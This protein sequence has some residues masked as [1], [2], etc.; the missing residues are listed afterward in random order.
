MYRAAALMLLLLMPA[1]ALGGDAPAGS[2]FLTPHYS[3]RLAGIDQETIHMLESQGFFIEWAHG[4]KA[5]LYVDASQEELLTH[6][7]YLPVRVETSEPNVPY[8]TITALYASIDAVLAAHPDIC[9]SEIIGTSI[10]GRPLRA[11]VVTANPG[12]EEVE[13][14][15]RII[16]SIH[17]DEKTS[18]MVTLG[19]LQN[20]TDSYDDSPACQYIVDNTELW[21]VPVLNPDGYVANSRY[22]ANGIDLNRNLS[23]M[24]PGSGGGSTAFSEPETAAL[25]D[26]TMQDWPAVSNFVNPF[27]VALSLHGGAACFNAPWNYTSNPHPADYD[28]MVDQGNAYANSPGIV[29]YFGSGNF[30][31]WVPGADWY[32]TNGDVNDWS[33]GECGT[34]DHTIEVHVD[35]QASDWPG[36]ANAHYGAIMGFFTEGTYG[37]WGTVTDATGGPLDA[38]IQIGFSDG[39]DSEPLRF[40][41]TDVTLG[42]YCKALLPGTYDVMATVSGYTSQTVTS[43][44]VGASQRVEVSFVM[45]QVGIAGGDAGMAGQSLSAS[46]NPAS[47]YCELTFSGS[48]LG[49]SLSIYD[50]MG[51]QVLRTGIAAGVSSFTWDCRDAS[52]SFVPAGVYVARYETGG[53]ELTERL[54]LGR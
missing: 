7:G 21:V 53:I 6:L 8:P 52:G 11:V 20:L 41:R 12:V 17:G 25:R 54:V 18:A 14:E 32:P 47:G 45:N 38:L 48:G 36:V 46:P 29:S 1:F 5:S 44:V 50:I 27:T 30:D 3:V 43:V 28:L 2:L 15:L 23:Y 49:G 51:R 26:I 22:N 19:F 16:G 24:G 13:P 4:D 9:R 40:C 34:V 39:T 37:I 42:D 35:K 33:Y 31:V 10:Q